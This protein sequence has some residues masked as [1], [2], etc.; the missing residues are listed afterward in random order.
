[1]EEGTDI[2]EI[3]RKDGWGGSSK[4][5]NR[6]FQFFPKC[7]LISDK[8]MEKIFEKIV[9]YMPIIILVVIVVGSLYTELV[10]VIP[11]D[12]FNSLMTFGLDK[13]IRLL[14]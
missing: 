6:T 12:L 13:Q 3:G 9:S 11:N 14:G 1:M 2:F 5:R 4:K 7:V 8:T 10:C